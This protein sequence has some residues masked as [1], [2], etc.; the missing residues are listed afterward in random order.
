MGV[1][2]KLLI[3]Q[4]AE[5]PLAGNCAAITMNKHECNANVTGPK[6]SASLLIRA[7]RLELCL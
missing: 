4:E 1:R 6:Y 5:K 7:L 2:E 3:L